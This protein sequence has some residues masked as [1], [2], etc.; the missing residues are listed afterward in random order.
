MAN[1]KSSTCDRAYDDPYCFSC[2]YDI[3]AK[4]LNTYYFDR[5]KRK[6]LAMTF[7]SLL[8]SAAG[9]CPFCHQKAGIL[10]REH[11]ECR[12]THDA[13]FQEMVNLAAEA[14]RDHSFDEK[15]L[16]LTL[17]GIAQRFHGDGATVNQALEEGWKQGVAHSM[18]DGIISQHEEIRLRLFRDQLAMHPNNADTQAAAKL[19]QATTDW[20]ILDARLAALAIDD[21]ETHLHDLTAAFRQAGMTPAEGNDLLTQAWEATVEGVLEDG[22]LTA[23]EGVPSMYQTTTYEM[24]ALPTCMEETQK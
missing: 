6:L 24:L 22:L 4:A 13:G 16:R 5:G 15:D 10:S 3:L 12:R 19:N 1:G 23:C 20:L 18:A 2:I 14:A 17:A 11:P 7:S 8:K 21:P 9:T